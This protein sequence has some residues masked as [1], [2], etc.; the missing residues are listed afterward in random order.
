[1]WWWGWKWERGN[2]E[3]NRLSEDRGGMEAAAGTE[4]EVRPGGGGV[5]REQ[6]CAGETG[7]SG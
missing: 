4:D 7:S 1:M 2:V 6:D 3:M 5:K